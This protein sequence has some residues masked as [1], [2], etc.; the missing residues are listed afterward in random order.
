MATHTVTD[1]ALAVQ[2]RPE[3]ERFTRAAI[4]CEAGELELAL[5]PAG[6][7]Q[8]KLR[9]SD[10]HDWRLA[11]S[12]DLNGGRIAP[13]S[14]LQAQPLRLGR[15]LLDRSGRRVSVDG[16]EVKLTIQEFDLLSVLAVQPDRVF[17]KSELMRQIWGCEHLPSSR[18]LESHASR[19]RNRLARAGAAGFVVTC[20]GVGYKLWQGEDLGV[21]R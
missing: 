20:H 17:T 11:C 18:T 3:T 10:D 5:T 21:A 16:V 6:N 13:A 2:S 15:L 1:R 12:G 7:W 19:L 4:H 9:A 8:L 14:D